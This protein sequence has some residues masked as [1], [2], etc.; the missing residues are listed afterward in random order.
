MKTITQRIALCLVLGLVFG[1]VSTAF[2]QPNI[3]VVPADHN[4]GNINLGSLISK[5]ITV[6]NTGTT[7][8][9]INLI[10]IT[11]AGE[12]SKGI[13][14]CSG[15]TIISTAQ[16]MDCDEF[17]NVVLDT[18][19]GFQPFGFAGGLY[20]PQ[21]KLVR[22][23]A[24]DYDAEIGRWAMKDPLRFQG[25]EETNLYVYALNNPVRVRNQ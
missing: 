24:R 3:S 4:F 25:F 16:R 8:L 10:H 20:D 2:S 9:L 6:T 12:F 17:G 15:Q 21:T 13:D 14:T 23:G 19:P 5:T 18:N 1:F 11:P 22:L 7:D